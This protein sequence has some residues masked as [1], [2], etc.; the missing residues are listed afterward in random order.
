[1]PIRRVTLLALLVLSGG[2]RNDAAE[3]PP[4]SPQAPPAADQRTRDSILG[5]SSLPGAGAIRGA[6][7]ARDT[8][9]ARGSRIQ[10]P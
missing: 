5:A 10:S 2:C 4:A 8:L 7:R 9:E 3:S 6:L 1:M